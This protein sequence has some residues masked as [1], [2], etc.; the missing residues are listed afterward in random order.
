[1]K[2]DNRTFYLATDSRARRTLFRLFG[3]RFKVM[4][5]RVTEA[6]HA[7]GGSVSLLVRRN[8]RRKAEA[9]AARVRKGVVIAADTVVVCDGVI[10][11]KP[12]D[13]AAARRMLRKLSGRP[14]WIYT[15]VCVIDKDRGLVRCACEKTRIY[16]DR[17]TDREISGYFRE[18]SPL[19]KAG[20]FDI[21]GKG[22]FFIRRI[23]GCFYNVVGLPLNRLYVLLKRMGI[24]IFSCLLCFAGLAC[25]GLAGGCSSEYNIVTG[26]KERYYYSTEQEIQMGRSIAR[27]IEK[28][29]PLAEDPLVQNRVREIGAKIAAVCDR[30]DVPYSFRVINENE[31]NAVALPG[32]MIYV[33]KGLI[34]RIDSDDELAAVLAHEVGHVVARHS[35]KKMQAMMSYSFLRLLAIPMPQAGSVVTAA[36]LAFAEILTGFGREDELLADQLGARYA[37]LAGFDPRGMISFLEKLQ[38]DGRRKAPRPKSYLKTHPYHA[39]R[40]RVVKQELGEPISFTDY[41]NIEQKPHE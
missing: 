31:V 7:A 18:V 11:G 23:E 8:A 29:Y 5:S 27:Q 34:D 14:Q 39:D 15:G 17:L 30:R 9:V 28:E 20:S 2:K 33:F 3:L 21:Q 12:A 38:E 36:D 24:H 22:A 10:H 32:G 19:D 26:E 6:G 25:C 1:M 40:I 35:V 41:I 13:L 16:M 4:P 37:R